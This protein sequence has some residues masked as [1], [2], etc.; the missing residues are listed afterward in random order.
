MSSSNYR[1]LHKFSTHAYKLQ[2]KFKQKLKNLPKFPIIIAVSLKI[3][4]ETNALVLHL[5]INKMQQYVLVFLITSFLCLLIFLKTFRG[6]NPIGTLL[7][8]SFVN[9][10]QNYTKSSSLMNENSNKIKNEAKKVENISCE[11]STIINK[12]A[13]KTENM[14]CDENFETNYAYEDNYNNRLLG[15]KNAC[16]KYAQDKTKYAFNKKIFLISVK[17]LHLIYCPLPKCGT[18]T[19]RRRFEATKSK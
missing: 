5:S 9:M 15:L 11:N 10:S 7:D 13:N 17:S 6:E 3:L 1:F 12:E 16:E 2:K 18:N 19:W 4:T 14:F 8:D